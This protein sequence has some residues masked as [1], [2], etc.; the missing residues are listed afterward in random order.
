MTSCSL[1]VLSQAGF[2]VN[3][4]NKFGVLNVT[5]RGGEQQESE[6]ACTR[7]RSV[8]MCVIVFVP[9]YKIQYVQQDLKLKLIT[10][11][12]RV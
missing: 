4:V 3:S 12:L 9:S 7:G 6:C 8:L 5:E 1:L 10:W 2:K 11:L